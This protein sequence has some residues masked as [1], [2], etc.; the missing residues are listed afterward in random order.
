MDG[1]RGCARTAH[2]G[3]ETCGRRLW[4][5][6]PRFAAVPET[7]HNVRVAGVWSRWCEWQRRAQNTIRGHLRKTMGIYGRFL[8]NRS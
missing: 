2:G 3:F 5:G 6:P 8:G 1:D 4:L 7:G